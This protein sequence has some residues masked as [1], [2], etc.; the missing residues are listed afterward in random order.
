VLNKYLAFCRIAAVLTCINI[1]M[2]T[3]VYYVLHV[4]VCSQAPDITINIIKHHA[5]RVGIIINTIVNAVSVRINNIL[6]YYYTFIT[7]IIRVDTVCCSFARPTSTV[8][9]RYLTI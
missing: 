9:S 6:Y 4:A 1:Y 2:Y 8:Y 5:Q 7:I 3:M